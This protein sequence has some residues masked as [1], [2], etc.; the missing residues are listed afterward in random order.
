[1]SLTFRGHRRRHDGLPLFA[2]RPGER[3]GRIVMT[4][5]N[6][7]QPAATTILDPEGDETESQLY[8]ASENPTESSA[9]TI[10][11]EGNK[12]VPWSTS[13]FGGLEGLDLDLS[14]GTLG[15]GPLISEIYRGSSGT[16]YRHPLP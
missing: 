11:P 5:S 1:M 13:I 9:I 3:P 8:D 12:T 7:L 15:E 4:E 10:A 16:K 14:A 2:K 6:T